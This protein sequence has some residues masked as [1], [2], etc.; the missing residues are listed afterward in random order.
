M[1]YTTHFANIKNLPKNV[2]PVS[3]AGK[4]PSGYKGLEYKKLAPKYH[5]FIKWKENHDNE[6]YIRHFNEEVLSKLD[7]YDVI[8]EIQDK[9]CDGNIILNM[10]QIEF[11]FVCYEKPSNFCHR[12]LVAEWLNN[13]GIECKEFRS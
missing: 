4:A 12:H 6:Y 2:V 1:F 5:F 9:F 8:R 7:P 11:A 10:D 3:I 13:N